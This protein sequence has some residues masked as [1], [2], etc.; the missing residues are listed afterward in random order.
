[1]PSQDD[2]DALIQMAM[3]NKPDTQIVGRI[4][5]EGGGGG[6]AV[7]TQGM[8]TVILPSSPTV[9]QAIDRAGAYAR[10]GSHVPV[11]QG[12]ISILNRGGPVAERLAEHILNT[13]SPHPLERA[14][15]TP[16][17]RILEGEILKSLK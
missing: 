4:P 10:S 2:P 14:N 5:V 9:Q 12:N 7:P 1:M 11:M 3:E 16:M 8:Q 17:G 13:L 15:I 6:G